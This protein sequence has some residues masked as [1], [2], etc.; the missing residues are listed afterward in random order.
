VMDDRKHWFE[1]GEPQSAPLD[2]LDVILMRKDPPVN[3]EY[4]YATQILSLAQERGCLVLNNPQALRDANEKLFAQHFPACCA[5][6]LVTRD[7]ADMR[8][9]VREHGKAVLKPLFGM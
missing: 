9:F 3:A 8:A 2:E 4:T 7:A 5:P 6:T 1:L